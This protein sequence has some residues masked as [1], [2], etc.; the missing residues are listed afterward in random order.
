VAAEKRG[1]E[2]GT[3]LR[4]AGTGRRREFG[5]AGPAWSHHSRGR[6][7]PEGGTFRC[8]SVVEVTI[9]D[10]GSADGRFDIMSPSCPTREVVNQ[11]GSRWGL[12]ILTALEGGTLR[13]NQLRVRV[14][15]ISQKV[16]TQNLRAL[17]RD[18]IISRRAILT[19]PVTVEYS[20]TE[21]GRDLTSVVSRLR[22]W[23]YA[24]MDQIEVARLRY[25]L[26]VTEDS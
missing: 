25:D 17:E 3:E 1:K 22:E 12:L 4:N 9:Y 5:P 7:R 15:G 21:L 13:F 6:P 18:G 8:G 19:T 11:I 10:T 16:L 2:C 23:S 14:G 26:R 20:L 24:N